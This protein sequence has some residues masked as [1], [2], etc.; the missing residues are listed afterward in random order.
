MRIDGRQADQ[1][2]KIEI[3]PHFLDHPA[4]S[5]LISCG[6][7]KV[8]CSASIEDGV[9]KFRRDSGG[10][11]LTAEYSMLPASTHERSGRE[12]NRGRQGGR[13]LE[14]QR[15]IGRSLRAVT[16]LDNL[17]ERTFIL[18][19][20]VIQADGGTRTA[21]V[22][23][24]FVALGLAMLKIAPQ[25]GA[26]WRPLR[27]RLAAVSV[28]FVKGEALLDLNYPED[29]G[30]EV[31]MNIVMTDKGELVE[32]QGTAEERPFSR[33]EMALLLDLAEKGGF[34]I[35]AQAEKEIFQGRLDCLIG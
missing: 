24:A 21:S 1:L 10:G 13:T 3:L 35:M 16:N 20:D 34:S 31:D 25:M 23:G 19:C 7:T 17:G 15:L 18:D 9:P 6:Q 33:K 30:A 28:G 5:V 2:R 26:D 27:S 22:S 8:L 11:W 32:I 14:I 4:G 12:V 29:S